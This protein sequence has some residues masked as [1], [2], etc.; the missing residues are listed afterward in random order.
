MDKGGKE[1]TGK[2]EGGEGGRDEGWVG[3]AV[4][5][6]RHGADKGSV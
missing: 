6:E 2:G 1:G 3:I 5:R 4:M